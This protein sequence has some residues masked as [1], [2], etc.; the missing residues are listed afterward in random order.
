MV[1][2]A[3]ERNFL[4]RL[5][6]DMQYLITSGKTYIGLDPTAHAYK[7]T[8]KA[9]AHKF[10]KREKAENFILSNM[11]KWSDKSE[12]QPVALDESISTKFIG[13]IDPLYRK[14]C[15]DNIGIADV[16]EQ[17]R[18]CVVDVISQRALYRQQLADANLEIE[19]IMHAAEFYTLNASQGYKLYRLL[20][21]ARIK[22]RKAKDAVE[23]LDTVVSSQFGEEMLDAAGKKMSEHVDRTYRPRVF[24][25]L[26][27]QTE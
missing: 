20:R 2:R 22:R 14:I 8:D 19:D 15:P 27:G 10:A 18:N 5:G 21:S 1:V 7:T 17:V 16:V 11:S 9:R 12:F 6:D 24:N 26:F 3:N 13:E 23:I 4:R 25:E